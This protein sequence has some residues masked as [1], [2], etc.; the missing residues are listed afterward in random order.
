VGLV[1]PERLLIPRLLIPRIL[2]PVQSLAQPD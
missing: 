2:L 1:M